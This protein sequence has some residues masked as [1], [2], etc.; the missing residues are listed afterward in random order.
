VILD[1]ITSC[2]PLMQAVSYQ[3]V[4]DRRIGEEELKD[5]WYVMA[6]GNQLKDRAVVYRMSTALANRFFHVHFDVNIDDW[7]EWA[8]KGKINP[9]IIGFLSWRPELLAPEFNPESDE[10][11][12]PSPRTWEYAHRLLGGIAQSRI[13]HESLEGTIGKGTTAEFMAFL[14]VQ[15]ELPD[16]N[17]I[18]AGQDYV[19]PEK[20]MDLRYALVSALATRATPNQYEV[21]GSP[22]GR[23]RDTINPDAGGP[24]YECYGKGSFLAEMGTG[25]Q[26]RYRCQ[27]KGD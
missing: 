27:E 16:L 23:V 4:L 20:R 11:A 13:L 7:V 1:E 26:R 14:K 3:L 21:F 10:K 22:A 6:A 18:F 12:F 15:T 8:M 9:N 25:T 24:R 2:P 19:P 17:L 5:G